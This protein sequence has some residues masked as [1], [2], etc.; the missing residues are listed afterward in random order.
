MKRQTSKISVK[1]HS[2]NI[3][4]SCNA[5]SYAEKYEVVVETYLAEL[6]PQNLSF[7]LCPECAKELIAKLKRA[8]R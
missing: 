8:L 3:A 4:G 7:R 5:C 2:R 1:K 6:N